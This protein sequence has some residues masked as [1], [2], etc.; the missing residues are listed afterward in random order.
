MY[1]NVTQH[2]T[3]NH[4]YICSLVVGSYT[5]SINSFK[6]QKKKKRPNQFLKPMC[7]WPIAIYWWIISLQC[8]WGVFNIIA[9][10][11]SKLYW[12][13]MLD[14]DLKHFSD[15]NILSISNFVMLYK[16]YIKLT[17]ICNLKWVNWTFAY[18]VIYIWSFRGQKGP[19]MLVRVYKSYQELYYSD[20]CYTGSWTIS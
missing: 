4:I 1:P 17:F 6:V 10:F 18:K 12:G 15:V 9:L 8:M 7:W 14:C 5:A 13:S 11:T 3:E 16:N 19:K 20:W 2:I